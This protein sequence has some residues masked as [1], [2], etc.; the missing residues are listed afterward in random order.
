MDDGSITSAMD[1]SFIDVVSVGATVVPHANPRE[2]RSA[3][4][5][6]ITGLHSN[7]EIF[8]IT[9]LMDDDTGHLEG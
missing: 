2:I 1:S 8:G 7:L 6:N 5:N 3:I 4:P 9:E